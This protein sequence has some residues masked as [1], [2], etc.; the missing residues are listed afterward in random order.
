MKLPMWLVLF[1]SQL[2]VICT[3]SAGAKD[4]NMNITVTPP[5]CQ[6]A[7]NNMK[8]LSSR[9]QCCRDDC[10]RRIYRTAVT[11]ERC[12]CSCIPDADFLKKFFPKN[13]KELR[14][15]YNQISSITNHSFTQFPSLVNLF[16][17]HNYINIVEPSA[18]L[19]LNQ[20]KILNLSSN[21]ISRLP[22]NVFAPLKQLTVLRLDNTSTECNN[23]NSMFL[24]IENFRVKTFS[25]ENNLQFVFPLFPKT[26]GQ[27]SMVSFIEI[28]NM[29][30][31]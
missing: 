1:C 13:M 28:F 4:R 20:L 5:E 27:S 11:C 8:R 16:V 25:L 7:G 17:S 29:G 21:P 24:G 12:N 19:G 2:R 22:D 6:K 9:K 23:F 31:M 30:H 10:C 18:F 26:S 3:V 14:L 15:C